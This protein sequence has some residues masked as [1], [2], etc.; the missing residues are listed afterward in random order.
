[1]SIEINEAY[2]HID[3]IKVLFT[4]YTASLDIDLSYQNYAEEFSDLPGKYA[5]PSGRLYIAYCEGTAAGCIGL[6]KIGTEIC[7][8]KRLYVRNQFR[9][10]RIG[11]QLA[12]Q[13]IFDAKTIGYRSIVLDTLSS[14]ESARGLYKDLGFV[15]IAPYYESPIEDTR[16]LRLS[17]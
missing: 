12:E 1:M 7:E 11:K 9:G 4:E 16:F 5:Q 14:M 6:R 13:V 8:I 2:L 15:E 17:L 10:L 3:D